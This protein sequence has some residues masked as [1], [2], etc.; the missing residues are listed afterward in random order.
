M[1]VQRPPRVHECGGNACCMIPQSQFDYMGYTMRTEDR[2]F[3]AWVPWNNLT[4]KVEWNNTQAMGL[5]LYDLTADTGR[6]FDFAG[7]STNVAQDSANAKEVADLLADLHA[8]V[9]TWY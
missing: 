5:E 1:A 9:D 4:L 8:E 6:D 2:R 3:T 7:Y